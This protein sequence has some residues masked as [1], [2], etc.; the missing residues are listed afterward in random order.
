MSKDTEVCCP[1]YQKAAEVLTRRWTPQI[2]RM[3]LSGH[4]Y[5]SELRTSIPGLSD[6][7]LSERLKE[8]EGEGIVNRQV[9]PETPVRIEYRLTQRGKDMGEIVLAIQRW[10]DKWEE[11]PVNV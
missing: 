8:L 3:L 7:L 9:Y 1:K 2:I 10:A 11:A 4:Q 5:F 6:R